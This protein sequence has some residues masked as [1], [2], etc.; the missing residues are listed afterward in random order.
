MILRY[1]QYDGIQSVI[2]DVMIGPCMSG[3]CW[4]TLIFGSHSSTLSSMLCV[5]LASHN[6]SRTIIAGKC[7]ASCGRAC[8]WMSCFDMSALL[9]LLSGEIDYRIHALEATCAGCSRVFIARPSSQLFVFTSRS[10]R[11][12]KNVGTSYLLAAGIG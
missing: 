3:D 2:N 1:T 6:G 12:L 9:S 10:S 11:Q 5:D 7:R 4:W 8:T